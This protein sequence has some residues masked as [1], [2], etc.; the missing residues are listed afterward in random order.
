MSEKWNLSGTYFEACNCDAACPCVFLSDPTEGECT[1]LVAWHVEH[2]DFQGLSLKDLNTA[3][4]VYAPGNMLKGNWKAA[5]YI[6]QN[7][8]EKQK[9]ALV[10]IFSG[11]AGG[12]PAALAPLIS[13][14]W[15]V[16]SVPIEYETNGK[17]RQMRI[18]QIAN[19]KV[20]AIQG[21]E[22]RDV[23][24]ENSPL[25]LIPGIPSVVAKS[26]QVSYNDCGQHWSFSGKNSFFSP[27][28]YQEG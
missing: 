5:L 28:Q 12:A 3:M 14:V 4:A 6:D 21:Q 20:E 11:Q 7:A 9:D 26:E 8:S 15:G 18:Q 24:V 13:E 25:T 10:K 2:G 17:K 19:M 23:V 1:L 27:F 22:G 16:S